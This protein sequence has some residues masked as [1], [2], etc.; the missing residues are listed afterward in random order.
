[1]KLKYDSPK[2]DIEVL[3]KCDVLTASGTES[4]TNKFELENAY[5]DFIKFVLGGPSNWFD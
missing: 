3:E 1:L 2:L 4:S 5:S